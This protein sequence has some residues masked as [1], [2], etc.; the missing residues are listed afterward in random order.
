MAQIEQ[1][2]AGADRVQHVS[3]FVPAETYDVSSATACNGN[4]C[5]SLGG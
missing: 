2:K 5:L 1:L 4:I 3:S